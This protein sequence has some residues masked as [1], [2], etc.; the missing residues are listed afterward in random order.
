YPPDQVREIRP[1]IAYHAVDLA[2]LPPAEQLRLS[3][4]LLRDIVDLVDRAELPPLPVT[5]YDFDEID[6]A[7]GGLHRGANIGKIVVRLEAKRVS[8]DHQPPAKL[9][10]RPDR[11]YLVA[12]GLG[13]LGLAT[14]RKLVDLGARHVVLLSRRGTPSPEG[15]KVLDAL[16][17]RAEV[18]VLSADIG[19]ADDVAQVFVHL[20]GREHPLGGIVHAAGEVG[21]SLI[22]SLTWDIIDQQLRPKM[23]GGWLLHEASQNLP[24]L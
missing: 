4:E 14:A 23:Y 3:G 1:D 9:P 11:T 18:S 19:S 7:F 24:G 10:V 22:S 8:P 6:E 13:G 12:G 16:S 20:K 2:G 15:S 21:N 5:S 17:E